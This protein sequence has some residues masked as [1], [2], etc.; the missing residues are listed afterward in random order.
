MVHFYSLYIILAAVSALAAPIDQRDGQD[1]SSHTGNGIIDDATPPNIVLPPIDAVFAMMAAASSDPSASLASSPSASS[2]SSTLPP[3]ATAEI[4]HAGPEDPLPTGVVSPSEQADPPALL[5]HKFI[6][7]SVA[8]LSMVAFVL[9]VYAFSY[10]SNRRHELRMKTVQIPPQQ[11]EQEEK[12]RCSVVDISRNFPRSKFSV[13]SSDYPISARV[14][15]CDSETETDCSSSDADSASFRDSSY[16]RGLVNSALF[17]ALRSSSMVPSRRHSRNGS[18]P[19]LGVP[20]Y[21]MW[22]DQSR[23]SRSV[24]GSRE[25]WI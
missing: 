23:R 20:R 16:G 21:G 10:N 2:A 12:G 15:S 14:S 1:F 7:A 24:S 8:I 18:V 3:S 5:T 13:T 4:I 9:A 17:F 19:V 6:F 25:E 11:F 22:R